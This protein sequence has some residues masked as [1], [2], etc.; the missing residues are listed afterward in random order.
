MEKTEDVAQNRFEWLEDE[1]PP[2]EE[3]T[4]EWVSPTAKI[5]GNPWKKREKCEEVFLCQF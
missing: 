4:I 1:L 5:L 2:D 3:E